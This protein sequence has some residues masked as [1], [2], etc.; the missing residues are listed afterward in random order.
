[1]TRNAPAATA[2]TESTRPSPQDSNF[3]T[4]GVSRKAIRTESASGRRKAFPHQRS[5]NTARN[6]NSAANLVCVRKSGTPSGSDRIIAM[7]VFSP[8]TERPPSPSAT[9]EGA[10]QDAASST[11][12]TP[13][14][15]SVHPRVL[16]VD[17]NTASRRLLAAAL[18]TAG[19]TAL[20]AA[21]G[22]D[23]L[24]AIEKYRP[25]VILL[26]LEM[27]ELD[28]T[29]TCQRIRAHSDPRVRELPVVMLTAHDSE[30]EEVRCLEAG[31]NDFLAKPVGRAALTARIQTQLRMQALSTE[32]RTQNEE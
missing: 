2:T 29:Q 28:G 27:P 25:D 14:D 8:M 20:Q 10:M 18:K 11:T 19:F 32:L 15:V 4:G 3:W 31:A 16:I 21:D 5:V 12:C 30:E 7:R 13:D 24:A 1:M 22:A 6:D 26:D 17:D 23:A 9:F